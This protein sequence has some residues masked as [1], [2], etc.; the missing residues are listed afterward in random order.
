MYNDEYYS[1][2]D[3]CV[4]IGGRYYP[5]VHEDIAIDNET[6]EYNLRSRMYYGVIKFNNTTPEYGYFSENINKN[7]T[8]YV[9]RSKKTLVIDES[10]IPKSYIENINTGDYYCPDGLSSGDIRSLTSIRTE[11]AHTEKGYNI[12][13]N[14]LEYKEK[15]RTYA[16]AN[17]IIPKK[18]KKYAKLLGKITFGIEAEVSVGTIP[19][20]VERPRGLV[21]CRDG[22]VDA[23]EYVSVPMTGA[24][25]V[26][27]IKLIAQELSKRTLTNINCSYHIHIGNVDTSRVFLL[28]IYKLIEKIQDELFTML[29][30]YKTYWKGIKRKNYNKKLEPLFP[31]YEPNYRIKNFGDYVKYNYAKVYRFLSSSERL[32]S[33][34]WNRNPKFT[35]KHPLGTQ[36]WNIHS[37]YS[38]VNLLNCIFTDRNTVEFRCF[39]NTTNP[40]KMV[41][42]L[43]LCAAIV[44]YAERNVSKILTKD[45]P[46]TLKEVMDIYKVLNPTNKDAIFVSDYLNA[47]IEDRKEY[48][49]SLIE[50]ND[51]EAQDDTKHDKEF[52]FFYQDKCLI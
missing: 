1:K 38:A 9:S 27:N 20:R 14:V 51:Y 33:K 32:P 22:S 4:K 40:H 30:Y 15:Q 13:D 44:K 2:R 48:F 3:D 47:Y 5:R 12:E 36:K 41:N 43:F 29:P 11:K 31:T 50:N 42:W 37:R 25:G 7:V 26:N 45:E 28:S 52:E 24:K 21:L 19:T 18:I 8:C 23:G 34:D 17:P 16:E 39:Q 10:I 49:M 46:I 6:G 35:R